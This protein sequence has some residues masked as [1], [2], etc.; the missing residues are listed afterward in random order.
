MIESAALRSKL[1]IALSEVTAAET[2]LEIVLQGIR[3]GLR[4]EKV[5]VSAAVEEAFVRVRAARA[6]LAELREELVGDP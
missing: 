2:A 1:D 5:T 6:K 4:A 3:G